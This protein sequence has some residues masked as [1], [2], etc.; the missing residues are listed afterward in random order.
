MNYENV[1]SLI[2]YANLPAALAEELALAVLEDRLE[3]A[4]LANLDFDLA[5]YGQRLGDWH[6][7]QGDPIYAVGSVARIGA[8]HPN[9]AE[10]VACLANLER[11]QRNGVVD[12]SADELAELIRNTNDLLVHV[13]PAFV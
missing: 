12:E 6:D 2:P 1:R 4:G 9:R 10:V 3:P 7:G 11:V 13:Y 5:D 8:P